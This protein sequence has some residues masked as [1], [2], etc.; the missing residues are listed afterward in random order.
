VIVAAVVSISFFTACENDGEGDVEIPEGTEGPDYIEELYGT[1]EWEGQLSLPLYEGDGR[2]VLTTSKN[3]GLELLVYLGPAG[4]DTLTFGIRG[5]VDVTEDVIT[6]TITELYDSE[7]EPPRWIDETDPAW[8]RLKA[9]YNIPFEFPIV[10]TYTV[11]KYELEVIINLMGNDETFTLLNKLLKDVSG[12]WGYDDPDIN[13]A[14]TISE[15]AEIELFITDKTIPIAYG[16][17]GS[18][19]VTENAISVTVTE[20][21]NPFSLPPGWIDES[22]PNWETLLGIYEAYLEPP[23][24]ISYTVTQT[25]LTVTITIEGDPETY[26]L[27]KQ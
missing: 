2:I 26:T 7:S 23:I 8:E 18:I 22:D 15:S 5:S 20:L 24:T 21:Y 16:V 1:W 9:Q 25:E 17:R 19:E 6:I 11:T 12:T 27:T 4:F 3:P 10:I 13:V 14:V